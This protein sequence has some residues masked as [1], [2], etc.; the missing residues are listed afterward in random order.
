MEKGL[1]GPVSTSIVSQFQLGT[2]VWYTG[3]AIN[4]TLDNIDQDSITVLLAA[5]GKLFLTGQN[6]GQELGATPFY[7]DVLHARLIQPNQTGYFVF[8][9]RV[10]PF[11]VNFPGSATIGVGGA[12]NQNSRDQI[13]PDSSARTFLVYDTISNQNAGIYYDDPINQSRLIYLGFGFEAINKP[14]TYPSF[15]TRVQFMQRCLNWLTGITES[16]KISMVI[17]NINVFPEPFSNIVHFNINSAGI[18][19]VIL[20]IYNIN[21]RC[22]YESAWNGLKSQK[23]TWSGV[24]K[25]GKEVPS[26]IYFY[27]LLFTNLD[28]DQKS[29]SIGKLT[30]LK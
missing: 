17:P 5:G 25:I 2:V 10:D 6:I 3:D 18:K 20:K 26:G 23:L 16:E 27:Q 13:A 11:G 30:F 19:N 22:V 28:T 8:G 9:Y 1:Q 7:Q 4:N 24:N 21:G 12:N 15:I 29:N 14:V